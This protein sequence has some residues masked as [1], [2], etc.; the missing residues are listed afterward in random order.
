MTARQASDVVCVP[1]AGNAHGKARTIL[2]VNAAADFGVVRS[3]AMT[4]CP[5]EVE[6]CAFRSRRLD[7]TFLTRDGVDGHAHKLELHTPPTARVCPPCT[8]LHAA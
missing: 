2:P 1:A 4:D 3:H 8:D 5:G 7:A 6:M